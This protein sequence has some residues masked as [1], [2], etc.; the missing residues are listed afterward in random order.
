MNDRF[1]AEGR[2]R[3]GIPY[4][5]TGVGEPGSV[6]RWLVRH[7]LAATVLVAIP[8]VIAA[9]WVAAGVLTSSF[10]GRPLRGPVAGP[11]HTCTSACT[12]S[13][14]AGAAV[15]SPSSVGTQTRSHGAG[16]R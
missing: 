8:T 16:Q 12:C 11:L 10:G 5:R 14:H 2:G 9:L 13:R 4:E 1:P 3:C 6:R 7:P 15:S